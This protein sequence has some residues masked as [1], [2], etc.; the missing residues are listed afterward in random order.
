MSTTTS[1]RHNIGC[2]IISNADDLHFLEATLRECVDVFSQIVV[3]TGTKLWNEEDADDVDA[4]ERFKRAHAHMTNVTFISY[5]PPHDKIPFMANMVKPS[6]YW[7]AHARW[8]ALEQLIPSCEYVMFLDSDEVIDGKKFASWLDTEEYKHFDVMKLAN[9]WYWR[10]PTLRARG[11]IEDSVVLARITSFNPLILFSNMGRHGVYEG[12]K[13]K[14]EKKARNVM[15][16]DNGAPMVHHF[17]WVRDEQAM[18]RKVKNWGHR[19]DMTDWFSLVKREF[20]RDFNGTDFVKNLSYDEVPDV[21][22]LS[23]KTDLYA[24]D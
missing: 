16:T 18:M 2:V 13:T 19:D 10:E 3:A 21:F 11:Y 1:D 17:S 7:E 8:K 15:S 12:C 4:I 5:D 20:S 24:L 9:Y 22:H 14:E 23:Y 6:M